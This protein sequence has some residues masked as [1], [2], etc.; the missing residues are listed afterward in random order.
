MLGAT[1]ADELFGGADPVGSTVRIA[2]VPITVIGVLER[3]GPQADGKDQDNRIYLP[4][5]TAKAR[6]LGGAH[7]ISRD[8]VAYVWVK[9]VSEEAMGAATEQISSLLRQRHR[10]RPGAGD[11]FAIL[12]SGSDRIKFSPGADVVEDFD[13]A[14]DVVDFTSISIDFNSSVI[15]YL[16]IY[17]RAC[18]KCQCLR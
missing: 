17:M 2:N 13:V 18:H 6:L 16:L 14:E 15:L 4:I 9:V 1:A 7:Q 3:K 11:D 5:S 12:G 10:L 8:A